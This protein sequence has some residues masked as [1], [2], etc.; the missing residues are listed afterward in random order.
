M[1][2][3]HIIHSTDDTITPTVV[4]EADAESIDRS[5]GETFASRDIEL[6]LTAGSE[7]LG[8]TLYEVPPD[9]SAVPYHY[10]TANEEALYV[11]T[12]EGIDKDTDIGTDTDNV[13]F[14]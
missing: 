13:L 9:H 12:G 10:H 1:V 5:H 7:A 2:D 11:L 4:N 3:V 8:C 14:S 6:G